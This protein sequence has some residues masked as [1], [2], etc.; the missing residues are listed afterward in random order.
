M[1]PP[2]ELGFCERQSAA[3]HELLTARTAARQADRDL[4]AGGGRLGGSGCGGAVEACAELRNRGS[5]AIH[6][7]LE[8]REALQDELRLRQHL[9]GLPASRAAPGGE[10][11]CGNDEGEDEEHRTS[12]N[13][14]EF[15]G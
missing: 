9:G 13:E 8:L 3:G 10:A 6:T 4:V 12:R 11:D 5:R 7:R 2:D 15:G 14:Q 1:Q